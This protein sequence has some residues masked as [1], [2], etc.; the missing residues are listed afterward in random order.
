MNKTSKSTVQKPVVLCI[1]DGWG[2]RAESLNNAIKTGHTPNWDRIAAQGPK[3][4]LIASGLNVGLPD[5]QMGNSEVG[6]MT[7]GSGRVILQDLPRI[8]SA[9]HD[10]SLDN[11]PVLLGFIEKLKAS[12]G[13]CHLMGLL[14]DGGVHSHQWHMRTL[15][16]IVCSHGV[17]VKVHAFLDG[18]DT[19]P[20][21]A[22]SLMK[23]FASEIRYTKGV[24]IATVV[25]RYWAMDRDKRWDRVKKAYDCMVDGLGIHAEKAVEAIKAAYEGGKTDEF[26]E[27]T[28]IGDYAGMKDGDGI[29]MANFR[30]DR[31]REILTALADP[32]FD[33][34]KRARAVVFA[35]RAGMT[36]YSDQ[37][38]PY[39]PAIFEPVEITDLLAEVISKAGRTQ[40]HT[41]ETEKYAHVT[42]FFN[43]GREDPFP[44]EER[45]LVR[46]PNV[47]TY[48]L[49]P[50]MSAPEVTDKLVAAIES[51]KFDFIVVNYANGDMV[52]HTGI[53]DAAVKAVE[54]VD[55]CLGRLEAA[56]RKAGGVMLVTADHGNCEKML[57]GAQPYTAHTL[58]PVP[59]VLVN[60]P[61]WAHGL[62]DGGLADLAPTVLQLMGL[63]VPVAM[64]G[65]S[66]IETDGVLG[67]KTTAVAE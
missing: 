51:G 43:G 35:A 27:P 7:I 3:S 10:E 22:A 53:M 9:I 54:A 16:A 12:G 66:L 19:P 57:D 52:G 8:D 18:R 33:G 5:G 24:S 34:F 26:V 45:I 67:E 15:A 64:S 40:L 48:D 25:G 29:L 59:A 14:S 38:K 65:H 46:S 36:E 49:Q 39:F 37:L 6:H 17:E 31:A 42:F 2:E 50:Q 11:N 60:A 58:Y 44:G 13:V 47:A 30:A 1:L 61:A 41:A 62:H 32:Q 55:V 28:V 23:R 21:S 63:D 4:Q 56:V 20:K